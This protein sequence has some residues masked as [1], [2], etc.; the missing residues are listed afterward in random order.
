ML[1]IA[2]LGVA[3][4]G[5]VGLAG[6]QL[7]RRRV[8]ARIAGECGMRFSV[9]DPFDV[10]RRYAQCELMQSGHSAYAEN[11]IYG[12]V[13]QWFLRAFDYHVEAAHGP[14][15]FTRRLSVVA[16]D[17]D[18]PWAPALVWRGDHAR[19]VPILPGAPLSLPDGWQGCGEGAQ[20]QRLIESWPAEGSPGVGI[21]ACGTRLLFWAGGRLGPSA[22]ARQLRA[23]AKCLDLLDTRE[24]RKR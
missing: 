24:A 22:L 6:A 17:T 18:Y 11:V 7:Y 10:T 2:V 9:R 3:T 13:D 23:V 1:L 16:A 12:R 21:Q 4:L 15:R 20:A 19:V 8:L 5:L 14:H